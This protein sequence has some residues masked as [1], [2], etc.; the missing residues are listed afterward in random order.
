M[1]LRIAVIITLLF[2]AGCERSPQA[3]F[4]K[5]EPGSIL[6]STDGGTFDIRIDCDSYWITDN[7]A[8]WISIRKKGGNASVSIDPNEGEDRSR[9]ITFQS[10]ELAAF[11]EIRQEHSDIFSLSAS[12]FHSSY[13]GETF[14]LHIECYDTW[15]AECPDKWITISPSEGNC[16]GSISI[17]A[18]P[19]SGKED[20]TGHITFSCGDRTIAVTV[21]QDPSPFIALEK[22]EVSI[23][24]DGGILHILYLSN[25]A[26]EITTDDEWIRLIDLGTEEK[27]IAFEILRNLY[28]AREG[29]I[30]VTATADREYYKVLTVKQGEKI[31]HPAISF[32]EGHEMEISEKGSFRLHPVLEDMKDTV[33]E[34]NSDD[35]SVASVDDDGNVTVHTSGICTITAV[36]RHHGI[37]ASIVLNVRIKASS[38]KVFLGTQ[39][40]EKNTL[41]VRFPGEVLDVNIIMDPEESY[42][43]DLICISSDPDV[44]RIEGMTIRCIKPGSADITVE[45]LYHGIRKSFSMLIL[46]D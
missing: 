6:V 27:T 33:L 18:S 35:S 29:H 21:T 42:T 2:I 10:G 11:L 4:L 17:S 22:N 38:I 31:D 9:T 25:T 5:V 23:D 39:D 8:P 34:W 30:T 12:S 24:G 20:R 26:V 32:E 28:D 14:L 36:N 41:A 3:T 1:K 46:E 16:P 40:M 45:S 15:A 37:E 43:G 13:K 7:T 44:A 19:N